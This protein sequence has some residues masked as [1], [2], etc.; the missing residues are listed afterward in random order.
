MERSESIAK[1]TQALC[2]FHTQIETISKTAL[3]DMRLNNGARKR[4]KY[5]TLQSILDMISGPL[6]ENELNIFQFPTGEHELTTILS[7]VSGEF[8]ASTYKMVPA[9]VTPQEIGSAI[10]YQ[11]RYAIVSILNLNIGDDD[12]DA[13][14]ATYPEA[15][16][17]KDY[18]ITETRK[19][20]PK[21]FKDEYLCDKFFQWIYNEEQRSKKNGVFD[22]AAFVRTGYAADDSTMEKIYNSYGNYKVNN[23]LL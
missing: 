5:A 17:G 11:R 23:N 9:K 10:T 22:M 18:T 15:V 14:K 3:V 7:H 4:Y 6:A 8:I 20:S 13:T 16:N 12:D 2:K 21:P 19:P 1:L